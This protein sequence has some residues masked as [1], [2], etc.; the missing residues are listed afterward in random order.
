MPD[1]G[2]HPV[3]G[4]EAVG[5]HGE[6]IGWDASAPEFP[7]G[8]GSRL[9]RSCGG[10]PLLFLFQVRVVQHL[11]ESDFATQGDELAAALTTVFAVYPARGGILLH[12]F[13]GAAAMRADVFSH[14]REYIPQP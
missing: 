3:L 4:L 9:V 10:P 5:G 13:Q 14:A 8:L 6:I 11:P 2:E 1:R 12:E 7:P